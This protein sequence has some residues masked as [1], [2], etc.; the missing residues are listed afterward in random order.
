MKKIWIIFTLTVI[1]VAQVAFISSFHSVSEHSYVSDTSAVII[2]KLNY[3]TLRTTI[4]IS[5]K[6]G[7]A[8]PS[9]FLIFP[10]GTQI[11]INDDYT[12]DVFLPRS[13]D[14]F[15]S[16]STGTMLGLSDNSDGYLTLRLSH[17]SPIDIDVISLPSDFLLWLTDDKLTRYSDYVDIYWFKIQGEANIHINGHGW[18]I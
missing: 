4:H 16:Y 12:L 8:E 17:K 7:L 6:H 9:V 3:A 2:S 15:G 5:L 11:E 18:A 13:G 1:I 10:N 14:L